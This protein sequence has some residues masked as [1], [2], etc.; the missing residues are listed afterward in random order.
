M[1]EGGIRYAPRKL[2][3]DALI[4]TLVRE[5]AT[6]R[7]G[8]QEA[9]DAFGKND[10][11]GVTVALQRIDPIFRQHIAD[12]EATVL[13]L[14]VRSLGSKGAAE[15][16]KVFQQHRPMYQLMK[17]AIALA[18]MS[19]EE[20]EL[21]QHELESLFDLHTKAEEGRVFPR[22]SAIGK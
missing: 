2:D 5:H 6:M 22:A 20:L 4:E 12:E 1:A 17:K 21:N 19:S 11:E 16:I 14:L 18:A 3:F 10:Y 13:G 9:R 15:E 8:L 7:N